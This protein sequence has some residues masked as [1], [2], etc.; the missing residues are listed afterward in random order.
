MA[1]TE[2]R[3]FV[4]ALARGL[5][6]LETLS[7]AQRPLSNGTLAKET[8]LAPSTVS[9]LTHTLTVLGYVRLTSTD[10]TYELT[11]KNLT[12]GYPILAGLS[13]IKRAQP[14]LKELSDQTGETVALAIRDGLHITFVDVNQGRNMVAVR[15]AMGGRLPIAV[16]AAG[17]ALIA[18][19]PEKEQRNIGNRVRSY[20]SKRS[21]NI[22]AFDRS[23]LE[24]Q[25]QGVAVVR[26]VWRT[27]I[28]GVAVA[29]ESHGEF[30]AL[31]IPVATGS[32]TES[33]MR[34]PLAKA[35]CEAAQRLSAP[36]A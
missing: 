18:A 13:L 19:L 24:A 12:L 31:V 20:I 1:T 36:E 32:V 7:R 28:G 6:I 8:G 34:G 17:I 14:L 11:A 9:R 3:Q 21:G 22:G 4:E 27:G 2:D 10:R 23:L 26:N 25:E 33:A 15:L 29:V 5:S 30:A 35:L 16:S